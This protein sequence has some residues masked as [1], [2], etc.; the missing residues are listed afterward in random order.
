MPSSWFKLGIGSIALFSDSIIAYA[1]LGGRLPAS[2]GY[3][4][5]SP[6]PGRCNVAG[7]HPGNWSFYHNFHQIESC[8][9]TMFY[10]FS[11]FDPVDD[12]STFHRIY[13]C[14]SYGPDWSNLPNGTSNVVSGTPINATYQF[15][16][17]NEGGMSPSYVRLLSRH[18][19]QYLANGYGTT[20]NSAILFARAGK[21]SV[22]LY[23]GKG[24]QNEATS[25]FALTSFESAVACAAQGTGTVAMQLCQPG[26]D[27][28]HV[29]GIIA[30]SNS[31]FQPIQDA[32]QSWSNAECR[33]FSNATNITGPAYFITLLILNLPEAQTKKVVEQDFIIRVK[34]HL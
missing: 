1:E 21:T 11:I 28:D 3:R 2:P 26:N 34:L 15:G 9:Q 23:M 12:P 30:T 8:D 4:P 22:G 6:C 18:I 17:G 27:G 5:N 32:I 13:S 33:L 7:P 19:R 29:F 25:Q 16:T 10:D 14:S 24:L 31:T 20:N